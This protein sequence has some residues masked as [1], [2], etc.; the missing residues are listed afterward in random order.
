MR[1]I[2]FRAWDKELK[3]MYSNIN[4]NRFEPSCRGF[5]PVFYTEDYLDNCL[6]EDNKDKFILMQYTGLKDKNGKEI[7]EGDVVEW[8]VYGEESKLVKRK[9]HIYFFHDGW[10]FPSA[11]PICSLKVIGNIH[12]NPKLI[13]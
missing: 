9:T 5:V 8:E 10:R 6:E 1:E 3:K 7:Y 13:D 12:D 2:K 4:L 11:V